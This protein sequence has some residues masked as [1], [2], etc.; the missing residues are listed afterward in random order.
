MT[1]N[2]SSFPRLLLRITEEKLQRASAVAACQKVLLI[3]RKIRPEIVPTGGQK[4]F[5]VK[6]NAFNWF[7]I[8]IIFMN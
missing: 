1:A 4:Y 3:R 7:I 5:K 8:P 6:L 2:I